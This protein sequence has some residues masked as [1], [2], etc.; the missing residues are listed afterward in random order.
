M[1][2]FDMQGEG[3]VDSGSKLAFHMKTD[4]LFRE[5]K[6][7]RKEDNVNLTSESLI[8]RTTSYLARTDMMLT[9][10]RKKSTRKTKI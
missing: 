10:R 9:M 6:K 2:G 3:L 8:F 7:Q 1:S 4:K 5:E